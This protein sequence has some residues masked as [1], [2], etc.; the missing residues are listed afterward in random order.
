MYKCKNDD[1]D[2][3]GEAGRVRKSGRSL[4][5]VK[6]PT[7]YAPTLPMFSDKKAITEYVRK[8][9]QTNK[10]TYKP[11]NVQINLPALLTTEQPL[12]YFKHR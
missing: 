12:G 7:C 10:Y 4:L 2:V 3:G 1:D 9:H 5:A 6:D 11:M 8:K